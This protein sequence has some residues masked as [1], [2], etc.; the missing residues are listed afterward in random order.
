MWW[1]ADNIKA[2]HFVRNGA[3]SEMILLQSILLRY[4]YLI[5][6]S[7]GSQMHGKHIRVVSWGKNNN[8]QTKQRRFSNEMV[9][10]SIQL[11]FLSFSPSCLG[12]AKPTVVV[13]AI[14]VQW[15]QTFVVRRPTHMTRLQNGFAQTLLPFLRGWEKKSPNWNKGVQSN[16]PI[17]LLFLDYIQGLLLHSMLLLSLSPVSMNMRALKILDRRDKTYK[18]IC[19]LFLTIMLPPSSGKQD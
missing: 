11:F 15:Q 3:C 8:S 2:R 7:W 9:S 10:I 18:M 14:R 12:I 4:L 13:V 6:W 1:K 19:V 16:E 5:A 17:V